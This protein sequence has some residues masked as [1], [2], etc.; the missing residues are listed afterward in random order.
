MRV[1]LERINDQAIHLTTLIDELLDVSIMRT[2]Y[3]DLRKRKYDLNDICREAVDDQ[4]LL[5][6][7]SIVLTAPEEPMII[8]VDRDRLSQ[9]LINLV[10]NAI[11]YS[12]DGSPI[13]VDVSCDRD[14]ARIAVHDQGKG[15]PKDQ[16]TKIFE[17]FYRTPEALSSSKKGMG[18]GLAIAKEIV[19]RHNGHI[20]CES[21]TG[22]GSI[23]RVEL[24]LR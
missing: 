2:G 15:I 24:S 21:K 3:A 19:E 5:T 18:L 7:R 22:Q 16:Q 11:K 9:V 20:W 8:N 23:F 1:S 13:K 4:Q 10:S 17:T 14:Y 12:P 6:G